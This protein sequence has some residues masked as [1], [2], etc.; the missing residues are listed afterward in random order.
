[1]SLY[2]TRGNDETQGWYSLMASDQITTN[3]RLLYG[4]NLPILREYIATD[5]VDLIYLDPPFNSNR[6]YNVLFKNEKGNESEAQIMAFEDTWHWNQTAEETYQDIIFNA[7]APVSRLIASLRDAVGTNEMMA[8]LVMMTVRLVEL[9]RVLKHSGSLYLHCDST[10]SHYLK[11][12]L[13][14]IFGPEQ[15]RN[16]VIWE[17]TSSHNDS[18]KWGAVHDII[19]FYSKSE[20][21]TWNGVYT[22][23]YI[24]DF[25][26]NE[27]EKGIYRLDH[28]IRFSSMGERP[29]LTY[30]FKG[31]TPQWGWRVK[32]EKLEILDTEGRLQWSSTGRPYLKRYLHEQKGTPIKDVITDI[33][34]IG[35]QAAE[36]LGYPTQKPLALLERIIEASSN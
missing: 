34:P 19:F 24:A 32:R 23:H 9:H 22:A 36:R 6:N 21:F 26:R 4:D 18:R 16:E 17:R 7:P 3:N 30:E 12:V 27:D 1:M 31:Y 11:V 29:N 25:Y 35:A 33:Q 13:D 2:D 5:S 20:K 8:Y 14:I 15:F 28:I 10:A